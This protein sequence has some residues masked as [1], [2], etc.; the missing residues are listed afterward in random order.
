[1][2]LFVGLVG[3]GCTHYTP[4]TD[5]QPVLARTIRVERS[6]RAPISVSGVGGNRCELQR[7]E[8]TVVEVFGDSL[9]VKPVREVVMAPDAASACRAFPA[10]L[11]VARVELT[12][13]TTARKSGAWGRTLGLLF[14]V[15]LGGALLLV[16]ALNSSG[17]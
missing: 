11:T 15:Y 4:L 14:G 17:F 5:R 8:G 6:A 12:P 1:M 10:G 2:L 13:Q 16:A 7:F 3:T 9:L